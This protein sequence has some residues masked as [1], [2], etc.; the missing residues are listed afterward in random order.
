M[1]QEQHGLQQTSAPQIMDLDRDRETT[2]LPTQS[3]ANLSLSSHPDAPLVNQKRA[4]HRAQRPSTDSPLNSITVP[5]SSPQ[6]LGSTPFEPLRSDT[7]SKSLRRASSRRDLDLATDSPHKGLRP[8]S[9]YHQSLLNLRDELQKTSDSGVCHF[10][11][12]TGLISRTD[13]DCFRH[14]HRQ[15]AFPEHLTWRHP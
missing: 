10:R 2:L 15:P 8:K 14:N 1:Q 4:T 3:V 13:C 5:S 7:S 9:S 12:S 6:R 11:A